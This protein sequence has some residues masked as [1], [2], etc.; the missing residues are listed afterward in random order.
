MDF[1]LSA[2]S[3]I[4]ID[5]NDSNYIDN[6]APHPR[7]FDN[8]VPL[9]MDALKKVYTQL[10]SALNDVGV[11]KSTNSTLSACRFPGVP[12]W[13][14]QTGTLRNHQRSDREKQH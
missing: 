11:Q 10:I 14:R 3:S 8:E 7:M 5:I 2:Q 1:L 9:G 6:L 13:R 12:D 4:T